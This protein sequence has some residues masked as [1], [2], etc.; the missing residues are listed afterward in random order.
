MHSVKLHEPYVRPQARLADNE[1]FNKTWHVSESEYFL[2]GDNRGASCDS[3]ARA[4]C[5]AR[6]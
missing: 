4:P 5:R 3:R 2:M 6:T 1:H